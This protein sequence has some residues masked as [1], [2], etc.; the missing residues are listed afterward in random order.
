[1]M[2]ASLFIARRLRFKG[3]IAVTS[4]AV[5]FIVMIISVSVSSGFRHEIRDGIS[6]LS[7]DIQL[8]PVNLNYLDE[9]SPIERRPAY[10]EKVEALKGVKAVSPA[11][12]KAGIVRT[13]GE[14]HGVLFK[15]IENP[16]KVSGT[17]SLPSLGVAVP[18]GLASILHLKPGDR[19][20]SYFIGEKIRVRNFTV[21]SVYEGMFDSDPENMVVFASLSDMQR[22]NG[23]GSNQ[24][25][26]LEVLLDNRYKDMQGMEAMQQEVGSMALLYADDESASV[27]ARSAVS[28]YPQIFDWLGLIDFNVFFILLLMTAVAGFNMISGLLIMLFENISTIGLLKSLGMDDRRIAKVFLT[29]ASSAVLKGMVIGNAV[30]LLLCAIQGTTHMLRLDPANYF[31]PYVPVHIDLPLFLLA[32][33][34]AYLAIMLLLLIPSLFITKIDPAKTVRVA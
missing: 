26:A 20:P 34:A 4:I 14:I 5:S 23:W 2:D 15:G 25:S 10:L 27:V 8:T 31:L 7:G 13:D 12:Y 33:I 21:A 9:S 30:A 19:L 11:V 1:M 16:G 29:S 32:D 22:L 18:S 6:F 3:R 24:V 28:R 17:D